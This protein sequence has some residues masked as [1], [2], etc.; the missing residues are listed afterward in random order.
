MPRVKNQRNQHQHHHLD[1]LN[2]R[3]STPAFQREV[4][5]MPKGKGGQTHRNN[6]GSSNRSSH[7]QHVI[8]HHHQVSLALPQLG[9][10]LR[11]RPRCLKIRSPGKG[12][13]DQRGRHGAAERRRVF[14]ELKARHKQHRHGSGIRRPRTQTRPAPMIGSQTLEG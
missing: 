2:L 1:V 12:S 6:H 5:L 7:H 13:R 10:A 11:R 14:P 8:D 3:L 4:C 9:E